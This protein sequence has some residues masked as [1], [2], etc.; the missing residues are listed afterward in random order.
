[1]DPSIF[2]FIYD[3]DQSVCALADGHSRHC[4]HCKL[5]IYI[6]SQLS[7][8]P[9]NTCLRDTAKEVGNAGSHGVQ[10]TG[11]ARHHHRSRLKHA[12]GCHP[13]FPCYPMIV[14]E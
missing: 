6:S 11:C 12:L 1:M 10:R 3:T 9:I 8:P 4:K 7:A 13:G 5:D 14:I 2:L